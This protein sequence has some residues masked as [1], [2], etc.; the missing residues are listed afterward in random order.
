MMFWSFVFF[1][2]TGYYFTKGLIGKQIFHSFKSFLVQKQRFWSI[3]FL[4]NFWFKIGYCVFSLIYLVTD[5]H[6]TMTL[7]QLWRRSTHDT[8][9]VVGLR[10]VVRLIIGGGISLLRV[11]DLWHDFIFAVRHLSHHLMHGFGAGDRP[12]NPLT[13]PVICVV[14]VP[15]VRWSE[16]RAC[17]IS[18]TNTVAH[19]TTLTRQPNHFILWFISKMFWKNK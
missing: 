5:I 17:H 9:T 12:W 15:E 18:D 14:P 1:V 6:C 2:G 3:Y 16:P 13:V 19:E 7:V 4:V 11:A 10:R 8:P